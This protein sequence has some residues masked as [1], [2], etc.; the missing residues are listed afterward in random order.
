M[1]VIL[2]V[3]GAGYI[4]SHVCKE[5]SRR[6]HLPV[7]YDSL[8]TGHRHLVRWGPLEAGDLADRATLTRVLTVY[9]PEAVL[10]F[11]AFTSVGDS[12]I[13]PGRFYRNNVAG[14]LSLLEALRDHDIDRVVFS[15]SCSVYGQPRQLPLVEDHPCIPTNPYGFTKHCVERMLADFGQAH[16]MRSIA[17]RYFNAAGADPDGETGE[18]HLPETHLIPLALAAVAGRGPPLTILGTDYATPDGSCIRDYVHVTDLAVAHVQA[19]EALDRLSKREVSH[20]F[21]L[22]AGEGYSVL[23]VLAMVEKVTGRMVP[24]VVGP[25][26]PG[27]EPLLV[28]DCG[29]ALR[30][31]GWQ[32]RFSSLETIVETAWR[33]L[34][35]SRF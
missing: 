22:G 23:Q 19:L 8:I 18:D 2:V 20:A 7:T 16:G 24:V 35:E 9:R 30:E 31:L 15:S 17:L 13:D 4:G 1:S 11:A 27:D 33:W 6:G 5:L 3:G 34:K 14:S 26:R 28:G 25:R 21:N 32:P 10:H 12:V 29:R